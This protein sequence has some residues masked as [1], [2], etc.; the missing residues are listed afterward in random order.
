MIIIFKDVHLNP[1]AAIKAFEETKAQY[2]IPIHHSTFYI[3]GE[4][5]LEHIKK[6]FT[7]PSVQG[8]VFLLDIGQSLSLIAGK[9]HVG[10]ISKL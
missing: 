1:Y 7:K 10:G 2:M 6:A 5:E 8:R 4:S 3:R 9:A